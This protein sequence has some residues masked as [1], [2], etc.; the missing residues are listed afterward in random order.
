MN[1]A[2]SS[3]GVQDESDYGWTILSDFSAGCYNYTSVPDTAPIVPGQGQTPADPLETYRCIGLPGGGLGPLPALVQSY[4]WTPDSNTEGLTY[5]VGFLVHDELTDGG[6]EIF[7]II[8][9]DNGTNHFWNAYSW[10]SDSD[11]FN[12]IVSTEEASAAGVFGSPYPAMTRVAPTNPTTTDGNPVIVFPNGGPASD[13]NDST[14][15]LYLYPDPS[16][17]TAYGA[18][19]LITETDDVFSS[20]SGPVILWQSRI[21][22]LAGTGY[23]WPAGGGFNT[24][25]N[26]NYTDPPN[27]ENYGF[28]KTVFETEA[29]YGYGTGGSISAGELFL[30][31]KR[32]GAVMVTGDLNSPDVTYLPGVQ[33]TGAI[34]GRGDSGLAGFFYCSADNGAWLWNGSNTAEK[35]SQQLDDDFFTVANNPGGYGFFVECIGDKAYFS[36]NWVYDMRTNSWWRLH[37]TTAQDAEEGLDLFWYNGVGGTDIYAGVL[38]FEGSDQNYAFQFSQNTPVESWQWKSLPIPVTNARLIEPRIIVVRASSNN[39]NENSQITVTY[40]N[41]GEEVGSVTTPEGSIQPWPSMIRMPMQR[42]TDSVPFQAIDFT[43]LIEAVGND[44][45]APNLW[46]VGIGYNQR[47]HQTTTPSA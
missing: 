8:E 3:R 30:V 44:A 27:S 43:L 7:S 17:P 10:D 9:Y 41:Q 33:S 6:I 13:T 16:N 28:Q 23:G 35:I 19:E 18:K 1:A 11:S 5:L 26:I 40:F 4:E 21:L 20:I 39:G 38:T 47:Q 14:G 15:Q 2:G 29:P 34:Y 45:A 12:S 46:S 36:N 24:N 32:G 42:T 25:E 37:P 31:K 22:V